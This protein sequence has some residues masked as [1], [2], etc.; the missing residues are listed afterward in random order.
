V[1]EIPLPDELTG[2][3]EIRIF[4][5]LKS[6]VIEVDEFIRRN[7]FSADE[8]NRGITILEISGYIER[9]GN[10]LYKLS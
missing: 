9:K 10:R 6:S 3:V 5:E 8:V 1:H 4:E 2:R 7:N